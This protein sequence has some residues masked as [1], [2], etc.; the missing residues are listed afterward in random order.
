MVL[1][2][3]TC[4]A[5]RK[6]VGVRNSSNIVENANHRMVSGCQKHK[7]TLWTD[8]G[9]T[10]ITSL[11]VLFLNEE[12]DLWEWISQGHIRNA[13]IKSQIGI[14]RCC[15]NSSSRGRT[16]SK[17]RWKPIC[18]KGHGVYKF[19][20]LCTPLLKPSNRTLWNLA[21]PVRQQAVLLEDLASG[22]E[23]WRTEQGVSYKK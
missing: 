5:L 10:A 6:R 11:K 15:W 1:V 18:L 20:I 19:I 3:I 2:Y 17:E 9:T 12:E 8:E 14:Y 4:Y 23:K 22:P 16:H 21:A 7:G 13:C